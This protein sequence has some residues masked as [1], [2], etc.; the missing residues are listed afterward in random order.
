VIEETV[1]KHALP[2]PYEIVKI[3]ASAHG[4]DACVMGAVALV[5]DEILREP[6]L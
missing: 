3:I 1:Q 5:L 2:Q 6:M 4:A